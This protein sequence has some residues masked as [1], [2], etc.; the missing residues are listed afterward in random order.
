MKPYLVCHMVTTIDGR[1]MGDRWPKLPGANSSTLFETTAASFKIGAWMVGTTTM[2]EFCSKPF[3]LKPARTKI[4][5]TNDYIANPTAKTLAIG[6]DRRGQ[7]HWKSNEVAGDHV[8]LLLTQ[9]VSDAYVAH[10]QSARVSY[11]FCGKNNVNLPLAMHKLARAFH[12]KKAMVQGGGAMNGSFLAA[13]L[14]DEISH[15]TLPVADGGREIQ[16]FFDIPGPPPKKAAAKLKL[17]WQK[18]LPGG[19]TWS[20]YK[21]L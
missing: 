17:F 16:T 15:L 6:V 19:V 18:R 7:T 2:K 14:L 11:L 10:L 4:S 5:R 13:G 20:K 1:I 12:L 21:V 9:Q 3:K 8:V